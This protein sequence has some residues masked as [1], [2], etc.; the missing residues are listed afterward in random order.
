V[1]DVAEGLGKVADVGMPGIQSGRTSS[2][3]VDGRLVDFGGPSRGSSDRRLARSTVSRNVIAASRFTRQYAASPSTL[4]EAR[5]L[6]IKCR[7]LM[8][9]IPS[10]GVVMSVY[11]NVGRISSFWLRAELA[12][13]F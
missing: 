9:L 1:T 2:R 8:M 3:G 6:W 13:L 10:G 12:L 11:I 4:L 7:L 5:N